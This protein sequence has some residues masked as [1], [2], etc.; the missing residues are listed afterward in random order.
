MREGLD[1]A[2]RWEHRSKEHAH[3]ATA[4]QEGLKVHSASCRPALHEHRALWFKHHCRIATS[5]L[6]HVAVLAHAFP[7]ATMARNHGW[8]AGMTMV[9]P[10]PACLASAG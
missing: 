6:H 4:G 9:A 3:E 1:A 8:A 10:Q 2:G 7:W 5:P